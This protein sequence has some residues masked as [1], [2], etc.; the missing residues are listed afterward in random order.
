M[1]KGKGTNFV[2]DRRAFHVPDANHP[3]RTAY[4]DSLTTVVFTPGT[5]KKGI[6]ESGWSA[7]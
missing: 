4:G 7:L 6:F 1:Q 5:S 2:Q 3:I